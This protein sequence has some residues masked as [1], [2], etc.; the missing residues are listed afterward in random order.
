MSL[1]APKSN[2]NIQSSES[3]AAYINSY[4]R[5]YFISK[6]LARVCILVATATLGK[7]ICRLA[8][9]VTDLALNVCTGLICFDYSI[10]IMLPSKI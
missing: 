1:Q 4:S 9:P 7:K 8:N 2:K 5:L 3:S 10:S 6:S